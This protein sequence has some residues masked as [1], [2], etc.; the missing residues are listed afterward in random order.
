[1]DWKKE[2]KRRKGDSGRIY[3]SKFQQWVSGPKLKWGYL[4]A[5]AVQG[6][7]LFDLSC[8][9]SIGGL[10]FHTVPCHHVLDFGMLQK[11]RMLQNLHDCICYLYNFTITTLY[12]LSRF[13]G[14]TFLSTVPSL[15]IGEEC[16][17]FLSLCVS[18]SAISPFLLQNN[19]SG[20]YPSS[21]G[22]SWIGL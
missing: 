13:S 14:Y 2:D 18:H 20:V 6:V 7:G 4:E 8:R 15:S 22:K 1:M 21:N 5:F 11:S 12:P 19:W 10:Y 3:P 17:P 16:T 9:L